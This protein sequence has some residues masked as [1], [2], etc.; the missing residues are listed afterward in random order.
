MALNS[1][2][3]QEPVTDETERFTRVWIK[4]FRSVQSDANTGFT[5]T[6]EDNTGATVTVVNGKI[7]DVT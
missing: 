4:W 7:T 6:F 1:P 5:G 3:I 2:P